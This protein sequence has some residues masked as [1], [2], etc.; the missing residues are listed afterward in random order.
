[1]P[2]PKT[3]WTPLRKCI[4][5]LF[6][7]LG[8]GVQADGTA[9][10]HWADRQDAWAKLPVLVRRLVRET[11][12]RIEQLAFPGGD[13]VNLP[14]VDG[15]TVCAEGTVWVPSGGTVWEMGCSKDPASKAQADYVKRCTEIPQT[16]Q[17]GLTFV[18]VT[19]RRWPGRAAWIAEAK[20]KRGVGRC[21]GL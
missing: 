11:T 19:P 15:R 12:P 7:R 17:Q 6:T 1:M 5:V 18:F 14:G 8:V 10:V 13:A 9:L 3:C 20:S 21:A 2:T 16:E 4:L